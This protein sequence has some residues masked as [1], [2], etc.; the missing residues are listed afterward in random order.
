[1]RKPIV[2]VSGEEVHGPSEGSADGSVSGAE[3]DK[4]G[5]TDHIANRI[6]CVADAHRNHLGHEE[7]GPETEHREVDAEMPS[8]ENDGQRCESSDGPYVHAL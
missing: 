1:M 2:A 4:R 5:D 8:D 3:G 7:E 6:R